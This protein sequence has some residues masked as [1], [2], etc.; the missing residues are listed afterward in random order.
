MS[1]RQAG[2]R[3]VL[4]IFC[5]QPIPGMAKTRLAGLASL[6][7]SARIAEAFLLDTIQRVRRFPVDRLLAFSPADAD[8]YFRPLAGIDFGLVPQEG[9]D[10]GARMRAFF[11]RQFKENAEQIVL[12]GSD[13]PTIPLAYVESAFEKLTTS[14]EIVLGPSHDGGYYLVGCS[15]GVPPVFDCI[16]WGTDQV[17]QQTI[18]CLAGS[19]ERLALLPPWYDVDTPMDWALLKGHVM[20]MRRA[21]IDPGIP[22]SER[23]LFEDE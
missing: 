5:K 21:G 20:A 23:L 13:S 11:E 10:L 19:S 22:H 6:E 17:L 12:V 14:A 1:N 8:S 4:G 16:A 9:P 15:G 7:W 3:R 18:T 2:P